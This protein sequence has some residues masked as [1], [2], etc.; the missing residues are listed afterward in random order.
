MQW[1]NSNVIDDFNSSESA[2]NQRRYKT[3]L[4]YLKNE[5]MY[6]IYNYPF[7]CFWTRRSA[8]NYNIKIMRSVSPQDLDHTWF[9]KPLEASSKNNQH[10]TTKMNF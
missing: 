5:N 10:S 9:T 7:K 8:S 3:D 6:L 1:D 4:Q 2:L